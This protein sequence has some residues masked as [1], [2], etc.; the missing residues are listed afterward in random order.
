MMSLME[1]YLT[2][3]PNKSLNYKLFRLTYYG[4]AENLTKC[5]FFKCRFVNRDTFFNNHK[6]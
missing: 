3:T 2:D 4:E 1:V 5:D 6:T